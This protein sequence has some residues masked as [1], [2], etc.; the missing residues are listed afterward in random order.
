MRIKGIVWGGSR[1]RRYEAMT[2]FC[3][4]VLA[5]PQAWEDDVATFYDL[6]SGDRFEVMA[7]GRESTSTDEG[8]MVGFLV[9]DVA[10]SRVE[11][12]VN[13]VRFIGPIHVNDAGDT[14]TNFRAPEGTSTR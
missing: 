12:E 11:M 9:D 1:T 2:R 7:A 3:R 10:A 8:L 14:W 6:A 4:D 5:M 13:G